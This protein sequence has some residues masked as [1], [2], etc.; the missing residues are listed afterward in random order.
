MKYNNL[1]SSKIRK[2]SNNVSASAAVIGA[3][4]VNTIL[5][6]IVCGDTLY[7]CEL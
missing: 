4:R 3:L 1:F 6:A 5:I 2:V 7:K